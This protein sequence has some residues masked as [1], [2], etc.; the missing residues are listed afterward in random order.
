MNTTATMQDS[1]PPPGTAMGELLPL[2]TP[3]LTHSSTVEEALAAAAREC[4]LAWGAVA[5]GYVIEDESGKAILHASE[6]HG[7]EW[8]E[9]TLSAR[10][11]GELARAIRQAK[12]PGPLEFQELA[13]QRPK[14]LTEC[15]ASWCFVWPLANSTGPLGRVVL[16]FTGEV[17]DL[18]ADLDTWNVL[19][20]LLLLT[21]ERN[22]LQADLFQSEQFAE[23]LLESSQCVFLELLYDGRIQWCN[24]LCRDATG[25]S[26]EEVQGRPLWSAFLIAEEVTAVQDALRKVQQ[27]GEPI[28]FESFIL[29]KQGDRRRISWLFRPSMRGSAAEPRL[30]GSGIDLTATAGAAEPGA[31]SELDTAEKAMGERRT[32]RERRRFP[33]REF[34]FVQTIAPMLEGET[35]TLGDFRSV[36]CRDISPEGFSFMLAHPPSFKELVVALGA[37]PKQIRVVAEIVHFNRMQYQGREV[38][39]I[40]CRYVRRASKEVSP[41]R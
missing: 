4:A 3:R 8:A 22:S 32:G 40:G 38:W 16:F 39:I 12:K 27:T 11:G 30:L 28:S 35:P 7:G 33:R 29:T 37:Q 21:L 26:L 36:Q 17:R 5:G 34:P 10:S 1:A 19:E 18:R 9:W 2:L 31:E 24:T 14:E 41:S 20:H 6:T 23:T 15:A 25:F 13:G